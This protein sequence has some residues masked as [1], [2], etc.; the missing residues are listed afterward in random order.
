MDGICPRARFPT[1]GEPADREQE[2]M[3]ATTRTVATPDDSLSRLGCARSAASGM[4]A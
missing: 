3:F 1:E 2:I 4:E